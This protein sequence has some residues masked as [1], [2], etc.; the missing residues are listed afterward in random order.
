MARVA[1]YGRGHRGPSSDVIAET[2]ENLGA[3]IIGRNMFGGGPGPW[4]NERWG[5][6]PWNG[7]WGSNPPYHT[8]V[9]VLTHH[10]RP[11]LEMEG[12]TTFHFV[13]GGI[14]EAL[15]RGRAAAGDRD[16][17][18]GGGATVA[19]QYLAAGLVDELEIHLVP[20]VIGAGPRLLDGLGD[21]RPAFEL[22][23]TVEAPSVTHLKYRI[24]N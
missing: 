17:R 9:F 11:S 13:T 21:T 18:I 3:T 14:E 22:I 16:V 10:P 5:A 20:M 8:P 6:E 7:W 15:D 24:R 19:N 23:R 2:A 12:G 4:G 1:G